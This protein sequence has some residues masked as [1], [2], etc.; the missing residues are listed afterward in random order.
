[1]LNDK[2]KSVFKVLKSFFLRELWFIHLIGSIFETKRQKLAFYN[3]VNDTDPEG[4]DLNC[5]KLG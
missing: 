3:K 5:L 1:M 4:Y 2:M